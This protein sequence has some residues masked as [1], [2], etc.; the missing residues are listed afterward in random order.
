MYKKDDKM[1]DYIVKNI[2]RY[3]KKH[4]KKSID[5]MAL[6]YLFYIGYYIRS[7]RNKQ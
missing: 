6:Q 1:A 3:L 5:F 2:N 4:R 7:T